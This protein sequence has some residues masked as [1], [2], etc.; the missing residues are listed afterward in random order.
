LIFGFRMWIQWQEQMCFLTRKMWRVAIDREEDAKF[1]EIQT[2]QIDLQGDE[3][4]ERDLIL[5]SEISWL[6]HDKLLICAKVA[7]CLFKTEM[8]LV[9]DFS[10][11]FE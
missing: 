6:S 10:D 9:N 7:V 11:S 8:S 2:L 3:Q 5:H 1:T 4:W